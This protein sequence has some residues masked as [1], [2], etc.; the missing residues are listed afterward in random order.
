VAERLVGQTS[1]EEVV[2]LIVGGGART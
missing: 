2:Q 1:L